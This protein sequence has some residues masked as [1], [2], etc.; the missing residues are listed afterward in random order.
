M[1][2]HIEVLRAILRCSRHRRVAD[3]AALRLRVNGGEEVE[4]AIGR[5][6]HD[7]LVIDDGPRLRLTLMG[8]AVAVATLPR[9]RSRALPSARTAA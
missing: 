5:L 6:V 9:R 1:T 7:G 8:L 3:R 4:A 2:K